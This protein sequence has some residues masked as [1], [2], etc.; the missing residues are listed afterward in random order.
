MPFCVFHAREQ[1]ELSE[2]FCRTVSK[3]ITRPGR[4]RS[5]RFPTTDLPMS[6][7]RCQKFNWFLLAGRRLS[8]NQRAFAAP[9]LELPIRQHGSLWRRARLEI[10]PQR[11]QKLAG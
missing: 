9:E 1:P 3:R 6:I 4:G 7:R 10:F 11:D 5:D 2:P 8:Q